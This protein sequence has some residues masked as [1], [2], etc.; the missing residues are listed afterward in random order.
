VV[1]AAPRENDKSYSEELQLL[2]ADNSAVQWIVGAFALYDKFY[3]P[4]F[5]IAVGTTTN[6][7]LVVNEP[8]TSYAGF[9]QATVEI[10][11]NTHLTTGLRYTDD[12]KSISGQTSINDEVLPPTIPGV[13][14]P[15]SQSNTFS[16]LTYRIVLDH[17]FMPDL[18]GYVSYDTGFKSGQYNLISYADPA[19]RP[20]ALDAWQ[21]GIKSELMDH[22]LRINLAGFHYKYSDIQI[23]EV[24]TGGT[25]LLNAAAAEIY[26]ADADFNAIITADFKVQGSAEWLHGRYTNFPSAP[27]YVPTFS[28]VT[29]LPVGGNTLVTINATGNTTVHSPDATAYLASDYTIP[30]AVGRLELNGSVSYNSG[31]YWDP[32]N[33]LKQPSYALLGAFVKWSPD[34]QNWDLRVWGNNLTDKKYYAFESAYSLGDVYSPAAPATYGITATYHF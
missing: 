11:A 1:E 5:G 23:T 8:T 24:V 17:Q 33:R 18:F 20:E 7:L 28:P 30:F 6:E 15:A 26:G 21:A 12:H 22:R 3:T 34:R 2:S 13:T 14:S 4:G 32:D 19:V 27:S 25:Q 31:Y 10:A 16:K 9:G 29:G